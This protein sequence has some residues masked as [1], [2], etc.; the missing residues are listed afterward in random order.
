MLEAYC[1]PA[2]GVREAQV[3]GAYTSMASHRAKNAK[4]TRKLMADLEQKAIRVL[5]V[6]GK[7]V[8]VRH[9]QSVL[10]SLVDRHHEAY[11][12]TYPGWRR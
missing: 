11:G 1:E 10:I 3:M 6:T 5:E 7:P 2:V 8:D 4:E 12:A 9:A